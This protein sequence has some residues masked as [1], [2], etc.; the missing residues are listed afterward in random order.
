[1]DTSTGRFISQDSYAG[2]ISDSVSLHRYLYCSS[3]PVMNIDPSGNSDLSDV[4]VSSTGMIELN[5]IIVPN[6]APVLHDILVATA[7]IVT[8]A[9]ERI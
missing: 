7:V 6:F 8:G 2:S 1:M 9:L 5:A 4:M 3:N